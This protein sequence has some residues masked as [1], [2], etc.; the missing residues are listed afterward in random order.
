M[1]IS[2]KM[3]QENPKK[4]SSHPIFFPAPYVRYAVPRPLHFRM[5]AVCVWKNG[6]QQLLHFRDYDLQ[7]WRQWYC[8]SDEG[9]QGWHTFPFLNEE[10]FRTPESSNSGFVPLILGPCLWSFSWILDGVPG[11]PRVVVQAALLRALPG[12]LEKLGLGAPPE[13]WDPLELGRSWAG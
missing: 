8:G 1:W 2:I 12:A 4:T 5:H 9:S 7:T 10:R 13:R 3:F 6:R 11:G